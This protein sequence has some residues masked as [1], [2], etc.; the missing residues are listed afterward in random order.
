MTTKTLEI[1]DMDGTLID[2]ATGEFLPGVLDALKEEFLPLDEYEAALRG[3]SWDHL[4]PEDAEEAIQEVLDDHRA[5]IEDTYFAIATNQ[6][7]VGL[8]YW[9]EQGGFG[10]PESLPTQDDIEQRVKR[11][12]AEIERITGRPCATYISYRYQS[13]SSGKWS[14]IPEGHEDNPEWSAAWRKPSAGMILQAMQ[15]VGIDIGEWMSESPADRLRY[16]LSSDKWRVRMIGDS[17]EDEAAATAAHVDFTHAHEHF[18][19]LFQCSL[20]PI[21]LESVTYF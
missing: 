15:D 5:Y 9:M 17:A 16:R 10:D 6:G 4:Y 11:V 2:R 18:P 1:Y 13:K 19:L 14:P 20:E 8:R 21:G 12:A 3:R 7:G